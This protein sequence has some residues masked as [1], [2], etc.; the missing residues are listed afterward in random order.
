MG[1]C[2]EMNDATRRRWTAYAFFVSAVFTLWLLSLARSAHAQ[3]IGYSLRFYGHGS[4]D[5]DRVKIKIDAPQVP[6]DVGVVDFTFEFWMKANAGENT[7]TASCNQ[8]DGWITANIMFDRDVFNNGDYGDYGIALSGGGIAFGV[9][10]GSSGT[11]LCGATNVADGAWH[12]IA[13]TRNQ[14]TGQLRVYVDGQQDGQ[15]S[16]PTECRSQA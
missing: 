7:G 2:G 15:A 11:T 6:A 5:I 13:L 3:T 10:N 16:G 4:N 14:S 8:N 9:N 1:P 12:H